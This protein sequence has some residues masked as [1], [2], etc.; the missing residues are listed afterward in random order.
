MHR[1]RSMEEALGV[2]LLGLLFCCVPADIST[3]SARCLVMCKINPWRVS[4]PLRN[5]FHDHPVTSAAEQHCNLA[6]IIHAYVEQ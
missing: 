6:S 2:L 1:N 5:T 3:P 4:L